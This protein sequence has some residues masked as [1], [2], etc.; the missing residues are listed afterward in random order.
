M[1]V[2][3][4]VAYPILRAVKYDKNMKN[5]K[6]KIPIKYLVLLAVCVLA[7]LIFANFSAISLFLSGREEVRLDLGSAIVYDKESP[8][9]YMPTSGAVKL[10]KGALHFDGVN[11]EMANICIHV[12]DGNT[13]YMTAHIAFTDDNYSEEDGFYRNCADYKIYLGQ[14]NKNYI[15]FASYGQVKG[16]RLEFGGSA[17]APF[18]IASVTLNSK[19][20]FAFRFTRFALLLIAV[21]A[22]G[23]GAWR[24]KMKKSDLAL[25]GFA[26]AVMCV[27]FIAITLFSVAFTGEPMLNDYPLKNPTTYDQYQ[28]LFTSF[29]DGRTNI[30]VDT[31]PAE[32]QRLSNPY[33]VTVRDKAEVPGDYWDRAYYNGKYYSYF[34]LAPLFTV[35]FPVYFITGRLPAPVL[36][37]A[38]VTLYAMIFISLLYTAFLKHLTDE[39]PLLLA[40]LGYFTLLLCSPVLALN[41]EMLFY[42]IAVISGIGSLAAFLF[43]LLEAYFAQ[44]VKKRAVLLALSG[45]SAVFI[46]ASRPNMLI[47]CSA[48]LAAAWFVLGDKTETV[49]HKAIYSCSIALPVVFGAAGIMAYNYARF[50]DPLEFGFSYQLTVSD[51]SA[52]KLM[53]AYIPAA[54]YHYF[55]EQPKFRSQFPYL[56]IPWSSMETY[57]RHTYIAQCMGV[58]SYPVTWAAALLPITGKK[59]GG[60]RR[61]FTLTLTVS[62]VVLAFID[63]CKAGAHYRYTADILM[64]LVF[65]ALIVLFEVVSLAEKAPGKIYP[66]IYTLSALA[67][68]LSCALGFLLIFANENSFYMFDYAGVTEMFRKA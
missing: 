32:L 46:A 38:L 67:L 3:G 59:D 41:S 8:I 48:A 9:S 22:V 51:P 19:P 37:S 6:K 65:A 66:T 49:K 21:M 31:D 44:S 16:L 43:F 42:Y 11:A 29:M 17:G 15:N 24:W 64:A 36:G 54:V 55:L 25:F 39:P 12:K 33:D 58:L 35:Y 14:D 60:F 18:E 57:P 50:Q 5:M 10:E 13:R 40:V 63:M 47:Y 7:E 34:G 61:A 30:A 62:A 2:C 4:D 27:F 53:L 56:E 28:Q 26:S 1:R 23:S 68:F 20:P 52:N 45:T